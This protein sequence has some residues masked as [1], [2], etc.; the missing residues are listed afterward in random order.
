MQTNGLQP[1]VDLSAYYNKNSINKNEKADTS[2]NTV[3]QT[4]E[5]LSS[6]PVKADLVSAYYP[7]INISKSQDSAAKKYDNGLEL[8]DGSKLL[9]VM[10][11]NTANTEIK[12]SEQEGMYDI[13]TTSLAGGHAQEPSVQTVSEEELLKD[14]GL[15]AG[16][17]K[18]LDDDS[19]EV[20]YYTSSNY[21]DFTETTQVLTGEELNKF[22]TENAYYI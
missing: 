4:D 13:V 8:S 9:R 11:A 14:K 16:K 6:E 20:T 5:K 18:K 1:K 2:E 17:V 7:N 3:V 10:V 12:K 19:Y 15:A 22:M 21:K